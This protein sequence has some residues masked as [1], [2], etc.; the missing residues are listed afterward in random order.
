[1]SRRS[2]LRGVSVMGVGAAAGVT[3][4]TGLSAATAATIVAQSTG[5][6]SAEQAAAAGMNFTPIAP[7]TADELILPE[8]FSYEVLIKRGDVFTADG[9]IFGDNADWTGWY[10][11]DG[12]EGGSSTEE[13]FLMVNSEYYNQ[14]FVGGYTGA[15][16]EEHTAEQIAEEKAA[17]GINTVHIR[18]VDGK[19][20]VVADSELARRYDATDPIQFSGPVAGTDVVNGATEVIGTVGNCSGGQTPWLTGLSCEENYQDY[21][22][23]DKNSDSSGYGWLEAGAND[24]G[25]IPEHYGWVVEVDPYS[26]TAVKRTSMGRFRHEN[27]AIGIGATGKVVA[28]MGDDKADSAVYKFITE[29]AYDAV[30][31]DAN[32]N[33]LDSGTL[34][35]A[36]FQRGTWIP[37]VFEGNEE[38]LSD[39]ANVGGYTIASQADVL[40][41]CDQAAK[42]LGATRTD[43]PEDIEIHPETGDVYIAFTNN[44][45]HGNFHGQIT[46]IMPTDGDHEALSFGW[47]IFA[48]GGPQ[49]G[50]SSPDNMIFDNNTNLWMVTDV[51]TSSVSTGIYEFMG[52]N[53][54]FVF[55][56]KGDFV[57][58]AFQFA[59]G[60]VQCELTG[61]TWLENTLFLAIQ[62]PGEVSA[63]LDELTS[64][65]PLGGDEIPLA[66]VVVIN[67]P[68]DQ[69]GA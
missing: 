53:S 3:I 63:S 5:A 14:L 62:H 32:L 37:V 59:S 49:S 24:Q 61:Q 22:G 35:V 31:R 19:W 16:G 43:R 2:F 46:R 17:V 34:Y 6:G 58:K 4:P 7:T 13:G 48:V 60:P 36:N 39:P 45:S 52:N 38:R 25:Q 65:W 50:F 66:A 27:V 30:N 15:D 51:S 42:A 10:P 68:F 55:P 67:G 47:D 8:G 56:T 18:K 26:G 1:M 20:T 54:M 69:I 9:R 64:N 44:S 33:I 23:E 40:T 41:Y 57:G 21:Y 12:L 11:I 28:Y 29:A